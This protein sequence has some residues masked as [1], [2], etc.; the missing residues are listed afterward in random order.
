MVPSEA[1]IFKGIVF[2][3]KELLVIISTFFMLFMWDWVM[4]ADISS[5]PSF[6]DLR[7][8]LTFEAMSWIYNSNVGR[9]VHWV[10]YES[11]SQ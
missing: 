3:V 9:I 1:I 2:I 7:T 10:V 6:Y 8:I 11:P 5:V 4:T